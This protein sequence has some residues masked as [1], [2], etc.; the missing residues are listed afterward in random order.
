LATTPVI[1]AG[2]ILAALS[3]STP[4]AASGLP[5][6]AVRPGAAVS[7]QTV[8]T[9]TPPVPHL[10]L[11]KT[12]TFT[13]AGIAVPG[14]PAK[15]DKVRVRRF[16]SPAATNV[17]VLVPGTLAGAADFDIVG[18]YLASHVPNLQ[19]WAEM[20]REGALQHQ[21]AVLRSTL[22]GKTSVKHALNYYLGWLAD[23]HIQPHYT[24]LDASKFGFVDQWGLATAM[25]DLHRVIE[26]A[27][28]GGKHSVI[29]GGHSLGGAEA[30]IYPAWSFNGRP[31]YRDIKG[32][33]GIDGDE[34]MGTKTSSGNPPLRTAKQAHQALSTLAAGSPFADL[35]GVG[36]PWSTG[37]FAQVAAVAAAR[38]PNAPSVLQ[39]F[40][41]LPAEFVPPVPVTNRA[42]LGYA[43]DAATSP[44]AL[45]L[46]HVH[47]GHLAGK[48]KPRRWVNDGPTPAQDVSFVF[49]KAALGPVDWYYPQRLSLDTQA[50]SSLTETPAAKVLGLKLHFLHQVDVPMYVLQTSLGGTNNAVDRAARVYQ[51][52]S[53][54]PSLKIVNR[55]S[56][57]SHLDPLLAA[58]V[59]NAFLRSVV[60]WLEALPGYR[61]HRPA[62]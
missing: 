52:R 1:S 24:P 23:S 46:I 10:S 6:I 61:K 13:V 54:I 8:A 53:K 26:R 50:A 35:L 47:S 49:S 32:I 20:R 19:V 12:S 16:G 28:D 48:G 34:P 22:A 43:F 31:G 15:Y 37:A 57:Y 38:R 29:L 51:R 55:A 5:R 60:P 45:A 18:P 3:L 9:P 14:T 2:L 39:G 4:S 21:T 56:T 33:V 44:A 58:P 42:A 62:G 7:T 17:L 27:R 59:G 36:L 25:G 30:A 11:G 41:L 40:P